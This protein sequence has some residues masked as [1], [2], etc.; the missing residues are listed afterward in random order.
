[1]GVP[2]PLGHMHPDAL[3]KVVTQISLCENPTLTFLWILIPAFKKGKVSCGKVGE[4]GILS[5]FFCMG[6][7]KNTPFK[8]KRFQA[9][10]V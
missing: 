8:G 6:K 3:H 10:A 4:A 1:V 7:E 9:V 2:G 5:C